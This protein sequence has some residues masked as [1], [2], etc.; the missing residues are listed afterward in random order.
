MLPAKYEPMNLLSR[1]QSQLND[2]F[3]RSDTDILSIFDDGQMLIGTEWI[4]RI[5]IKEDETQYIVTADIPGVD[6]KD[7]TVTMEN[8]TLCIKG[9]R[10]SEKEEKKKNY[11]RRECM[12][13]SFE[14]SFRMPDSADS[15]MVSAKG[16]NGVLTIRIGK[17]E[18]AKPKA[19]KIDHE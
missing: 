12:M 2:F 7:V 9:E 8:G 1:M 18:V 17:K 14:R 4:P 5:D 6:L 19:I 11:H 3:H 16:K 10:K 13:G 15:S